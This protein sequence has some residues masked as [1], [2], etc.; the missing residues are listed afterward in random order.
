[1][2]SGSKGGCGIGPGLVEDRIR[3]PLLGEDPYGGTVLTLTLAALKSKENADARR[4]L[5][6]VDPH[7]H[8]EGLVDRLLVVLVPDL[9]PPLLK[10]HHNNGPPLRE[11]KSE[12]SVARL[13]AA[14]AG[15]VPYVASLYPGPMQ[16]AKHTNERPHHLI[17]DALAPIVRAINPAT[18][19]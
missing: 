1:M 12:E 16:R 15:I 13:D 9:L 2:S 17:A 14:V 18:T 10:H 4:L 19:G 11:F 7:H 3:S 5:E 8:G 6:L